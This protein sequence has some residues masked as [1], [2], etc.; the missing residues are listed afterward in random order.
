MTLPWGDLNAFVRDEHRGVI[1]PADGHAL[2]ISTRAL[3]RRA[4]IDAWDEP[5][6]L[7]WLLPG[8]EL[9]DEIRALAAVRAA[10]QR[11]LVSGWTA[12]AM[13]GL[14]RNH[15][16]NVHLLLPHDRRAPA[17]TDAEV[18]RSRRIVRADAIDIDRVRC[19]TLPR[20]A[21]TLAAA[22]ADPTRIRDLLIDGVQRRKATLSDVL[23]LLERTGGVTGR[24]SLD[25][26]VAELVRDQVDSGLELDTTRKVRPYGFRPYSSPFP[27]RCHDASV[28]HL[29]LAFPGA[30]HAIECDGAGYHMD[31]RSFETDRIR[32]SKIQRAGV[33]ITWVTRK[34]LDTDLQGIIEELRDA[35]DRVDPQRPS[36]VPAH[37]CRITCGRA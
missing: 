31:R 1:V 2:G 29:D 37:D 35:H 3:R 16:Q 8:V 13:M 30:H 6:L 11:A 17:L 4:V 32:W 15:P 28:V 34:R 14:V 9:S 20:T 27:L 18:T 24:P 22:D 5:Q 7:T 21:L 25:R 12:A 33:T 19:T 23:T 10:G 36:L 26:I